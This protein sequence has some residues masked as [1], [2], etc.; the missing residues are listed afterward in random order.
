[1]EG[2]N[3]LVGLGLSQPG[4]GKCFKNGQ[5]IG[6]RWEVVGRGA[7]PLP[8]YTQNTP[9]RGTILIEHLQ[10]EDLR[11]LKAQE[12]LHVTGW[13]KRKKKER[14]KGTRA[15]LAPPGGSCE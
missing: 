6:S 12:N 2:E 4:Y 11:L 13:D 15:G 3:F 10:A 1:M 14:E 7:H 8:Q 5:D 9:P